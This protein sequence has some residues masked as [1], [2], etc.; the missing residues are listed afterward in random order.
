MSETVSRMMKK[1]TRNMSATLSVERT[2]NEKKNAW[3]VWAVRMSYNS[4]KNR[5]EFHLN[6]LETE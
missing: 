2:T 3:L 4:Q 6:N 1:S 5:I